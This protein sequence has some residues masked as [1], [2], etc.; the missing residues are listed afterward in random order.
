LSAENS[1][2]HRWAKHT[3][4]QAIARMIRL[5]IVRAMFLGDEKKFPLFIMNQKKAGRPS[6]ISQ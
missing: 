5:I 6:V 2:S 4:A 1:K 3:I